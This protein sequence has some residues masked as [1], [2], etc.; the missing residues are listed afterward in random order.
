MKS[1]IVLMLLICFSATGI[2]LGQNVNLDIS[3]C[4]SMLNVLTA[5]KNGEPEQKVSSMLDSVLSTEAYEIMFRHYTNHLPVDV[6]KRMIMSLRFEDQY[7]E[8]ENSRADQMLPFWKKYYSDL[9]LYKRNLKQL[10]KADLH[11]LIIDGVAF[12]KSW[13]PPDWAIPDFTLSIHPN[14]G[15]TAFALGT[16][17]GYDFFQLPRDDQGDINID[18]LIGMISHESHHLGNHG[19]IPC[20]MSASDTIAFR[21]LSMFVGEGTANKLVNNYPGSR[22]PRVDPSRKAAVFGDPLTKK[23]WLQYSNK[24][25][26]LFDHFITSFQKAYSGKLSYKDLNKEIGNYWLNG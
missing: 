9:R 5:M 1:K 11:K 20:A 24:E 6:F 19:R 23:Y 10:K 14:G 3:A 22:V 15:S 17:Q 12:A 26:T 7:T 21:F 13:L 4:G 16:V 25:S 8:G 2:V 18:K